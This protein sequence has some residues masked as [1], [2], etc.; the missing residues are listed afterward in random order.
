MNTIFILIRTIVYFYIFLTI[1][2]LNTNQ[3][4]DL[5]GLSPIKAFCIAVKKRLELNRVNLSWHLFII[6]LG[7]VLNLKFHCTYS[8]GYRAITPRL[9]VLGYIPYTSIIIYSI[10]VIF[11]GLNY[12]YKILFRIFT[13]EKII[14]IFL[15]LSF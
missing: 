11:L 6:Y 3:W 7:L 14:F 8:G 5:K 9:F 13:L 10:V 12:K 1:T 15:G 4:D 2:H